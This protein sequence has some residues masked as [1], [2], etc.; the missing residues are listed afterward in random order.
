MYVYSVPLGNPLNEL[1]F[2][3][4]KDKPIQMQPFS[5]DNQVAS[6]CVTFQD[7]KGALQQL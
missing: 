6:L 3:G 1:Y 4:N 5:T 2:I 7:P